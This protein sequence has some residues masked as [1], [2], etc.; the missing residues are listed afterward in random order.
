LGTA[1]QAEAEQPRPGQRALLEV[2]LDLAHE[3]LGSVLTW[4]EMDLGVTYLCCYDLG[5]GREPPPGY[6]IPVLAGPCIFC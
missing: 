4:P 2:D 1:P 3:T 6:C 5:D